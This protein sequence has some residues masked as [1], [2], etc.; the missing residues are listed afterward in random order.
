MDTKLKNLNTAR[1]ALGKMGIKLETGYGHSATKAER[2]AERANLRRGINTLRGQAMEA[3]EKQD[4]DRHDEIAKEIDACADI[5]D[6]ISNSLDLDERAKELWGEKSTATSS[7]LRDRDGRR[8]GT[9]LSNSDLRDIGTL[10]AKLGHRTGDTS[11]AEDESQPS[12]H[13]FFRGVAGMRTTDSVRNALTEGTDSSGGYAVPSILLPGIL[14]ALV[15][16]SSLLQA[17]AHIGMIETQQAKSFNIAAID[18]IPTAAWRAEAGTVTESDPTFRSITITPQSLS[19]LFKVTRELLMDAPGMEQALRTAIAQAFAKELDRAGLRGSGT[20]PEIKGLLNMSGVNSLV[21]GTG[22]GETPTDFSPFV[23]A[24]RLIADA[25]APM[26]NAAIMS[27]RED[28]TVNLFADTTGQPLRRPESLKDWQFLTTSQIPTNLTVGTSVDCSEMYVGN[29]SQF[30]YFMREGI[31][32]M[33]LPE[34][35]A[36]TGEIGFVCHTRVDVAA[37]YGQAFTVITGV[38]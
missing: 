37:A 23:K 30:T 15:P 38:R 22:D 9:L 25:N 26:P 3:L 20:A 5:I 33:Q 35:Y 31:S 36:A 34:L 28:E 19:F 29:F 2:L 1:A 16:A 11:I 27:T 7:D 14:N 32:V 10:S 17:G 4:Y 18:T 24:R 12:L 21:L 13:D 6:H 8:I